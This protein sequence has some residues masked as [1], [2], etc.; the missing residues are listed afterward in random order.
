MTN[1]GTGQIELLAKVYGVQYGTCLNTEEMT[2]ENMGDARETF[3]DRGWQKVRGKGWRCQGC[4]DKE[5]GIIRPL[6]EKRD[7]RLRREW[8]EIGDR[9][10]D[11]DDEG[12][13]GQ[14]T[15]EEIDGSYVV[16]WDG[17]DYSSR[18][19]RQLIPE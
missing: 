6:G 19:A 14:V 7:Q 3:E 9:V 15:S 10:I 11:P 2:A 16:R 18:L 13:T 1:R 4:L 17:G 8:Y 12:E 5:A